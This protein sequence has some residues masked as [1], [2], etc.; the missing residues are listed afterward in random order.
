VQRAFP[1]NANHPPDD[2]R[3][4][5]IAAL[6]RI[7]ANLKTTP[8]EPWLLAMKC[9]LLLQLRELESLEEASAKFI[10]LQPDNPLAKLYRPARGGNPRQHRGRATLLLQA[11]SES[12][13]QLPPMTATVAVNLIEMM[14]NEA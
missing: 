9:E 1:G 3:E 2:C 12:Q 10:R 6:D 14:A 13:E 4:Q 5:N 7:N 11:I 8:S